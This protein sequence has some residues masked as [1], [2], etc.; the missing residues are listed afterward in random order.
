MARLTSLLILLFASYTTALP[1]NSQQPLAGWTAP[2]ANQ[3]LVWGSHNRTA[4]N[5][6]QAVTCTARQAKLFVRNSSPHEVL[7]TVLTFAV[8]LQTKY[9]WL[10]FVA[11]A[12]AK[13]DFRLRVHLLEAPLSCPFPTPGRPIPKPSE[14][15]YFKVTPKG[16]NATW[17]DRINWDL[18][19]P[20]FSKCVNLAK[21]Q[22]VELV[23]QEGVGDINLV[24]NQGDEAGLRL[25]VSD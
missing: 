15:G 12:G 2:V 11:P 16:G 19:Y 20:G 7:S 18:N 14:A 1:P 22:G 8:P 25:M 9:C 21:F 17:V 5:P 6:S 4:I 13:N 23:P 24:W 10:E 3:P